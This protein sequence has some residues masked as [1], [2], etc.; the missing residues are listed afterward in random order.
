MKGTHL[1]AAAVTLVLGAQPT[2]A[3]I[4]AADRQAVESFI[5]TIQGERDFGTD[6]MT[7]PPSGDELTYLMNLRFCKPGGIQKAFSN[8]LEVNWSCKIDGKHFR[9]ITDFLIE[10]GRISKVG[11]L[12]DGGTVIGGAP[13]HG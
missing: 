12:D 6:F 11:V 5:A 8:T 7:K 10:G 13:A 1:A 9:K 4:P 2:L 3:E